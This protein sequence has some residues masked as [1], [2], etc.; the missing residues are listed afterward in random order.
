VD[1]AETGEEQVEEENVEREAQEEE[2]QTTADFLVLRR[3]KALA[4]EWTSEELGRCFWLTPK[5]V[6]EVKTCRGAANRLGFALNLLLMR[7]LHCPFP[8]HG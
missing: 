1:K 5:D 3:F 2:Q 4:G 6:L 7:L 8:E